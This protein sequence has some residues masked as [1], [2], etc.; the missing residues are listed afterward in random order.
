M[1]IPNACDNNP[2]PDGLLSREVR[3]LDRHSSLDWVSDSELA[4]RAG[5]PHVRLEENESADNA[6]QKHRAPE[7]SHPPQ[8]TLGKQ[9]CQVGNFRKQSP[10][11]ANIRCGGEMGKVLRNLPCLPRHGGS[12]SD[13]ASKEEG[14]Q[15]RPPC[16][17]QKGG[18]RLTRSRVA[19][20]VARSHRP[21]LEIPMQ[22][23]ATFRPQPETRTC[24]SVRR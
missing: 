4:V 3:N 1:T 22:T 11:H 9:T 19:A 12:T 21:R 6:K 18:I 23:N 16:Q 5:A 7:E 8:V 13:A 14:T 10:P 24:P 2:T 20:L 15:R 17:L